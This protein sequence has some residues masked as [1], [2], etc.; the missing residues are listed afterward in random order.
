V[1]VVVD[2]QVARMS[3]L[4]RRPTTEARST[5]LFS[6]D[7]VSRMAR[8]DS[9][10]MYVDAD[11]AMRHDAVWA[12]VTAISQGVSMMP[13]DVVRYSDGRRLEVSPT[14]QIVAAPSVFAAPLDWRYQV[15]ASWL[16][17]GNVW[18]LVTQTTANGM[19][20]TRIELQ[21]P[22]CVR[23]QNL[24]DGV[25]VFV[26]NVE[27]QLWP[28]GDLWHVPAYTMPGQFLGLSPIGYHAASIGMGLTAQKFGSD[29]LADGGHPSAILSPEQTPTQE[30]AE[31]LK[32][33]FMELTRGNREPVV[34]PQSTKYTAIQINP[35]ESQFLNTMR[36]S[37]EQIIGRVF[38]EDPADYGASAG[39]SG[40]LIYANRTDTDLARFK[41]RQFWITKLETCLTDLLPRPQ[42]VKVNASAVLRM[43]DQ[44]RHEL[45]KLRLESKTITVNEVRR[46][47]DE[48]PFPGEAFDEPGV[49]DAH[50]D[51]TPDPTTEPTPTMQG[52]AA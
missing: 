52:G 12:C 3:L 20:P 24:G 44:E 9:R 42:V 33:R 38:L 17:A 36:Y 21:S 14:P 7:L 5:P 45:F 47:E 50:A 46:I 16:T 30:Q 43:S 6:A 23:V 4:F 29:Y 10:G 11:S 35:E 41:R 18:G 51:P 13:V 28:V 25:K 37:S 27:H 1:V 22:A 49:P 31:T 26:D 34:L 19:Y 40:S 8:A 32:R 48:T 2:G 39:S 15:L